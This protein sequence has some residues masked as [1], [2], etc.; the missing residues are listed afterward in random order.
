MARRFLFVAT[1]AVFVI[2]LP[3]GAGAQ[4]AVPANAYLAPGS[5]AG[6]ELKSFTARDAQPLYT[7]ALKAACANAAGVDAAL[8]KGPASGNGVLLGTTD[9]RIV[10]SESIHVFP[11]AKAAKQFVSAGRASSNC[12]G[13]GGHDSLNRVF[14][15]YP[16]PPP[17]PTFAP[18]LTRDGTTTSAF[19]DGTSDAAP[20][21]G[22]TALVAWDEFVAETSIRIAVPKPGELAALSERVL[23][24]VAYNGRAATGAATDPKLTQQADALAQA[25]LAS[26]ASAPYAFAPAPRAGIPA[27]PPSC[28]ANTD[29]FVYSGVNGAIRGFAGQDATTHVTA[30][31]E[32]I[33]YPK[34]ADADRYRNYYRDLGQCLGDLYKS[35]LPAGSTVDVQ[36][37]P[38]RGTG[39]VPKNSAA[40]SV[41]YVSTLKGPDG[42]QLGKTA[43]AVVTVRN[44]AAAVVAQ[45]ISSDP[46]ANITAT[47]D[48]L[49][50]RWDQCWR[51]T[52]RRV[53][54]QL[55]TLS[56]CPRR[57]CPRSAAVRDLHARR[58]CSLVILACR[59]ACTSA[60]DPRRSESRVIFPW[61]RSCLFASPADLVACLRALSL[62]VAAAGL[63][64]AN[65]ST[66]TTTAA[67][68]PRLKRSMSSL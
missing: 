46:A 41:A 48:G 64:D 52:E 68:A 42:V 37:H 67:I 29:A 56:S 4:T 19:F 16:Q 14:M 50:T 8:T 43:V 57:S 31:P 22:V 33:V 13:Y 21:S 23:G 5:Y 54:Q 62:L 28:K 44:R 34:P 65:A 40:K 18:T 6:A 66:E 45:L 27:N 58:F 17:L 10:V 49:R 30:R 53:A 32:I 20:L 3:V 25:F 38:R 15:Q 63:A 39:S 59:L 1:A 61:S 36:R 7:D 26:P 35:G 11:N 9:G 55:S 47:V 60:F 51:R 12:I 24:S 2:A